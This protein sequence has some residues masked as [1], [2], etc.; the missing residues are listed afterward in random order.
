MIDF[1]HAHTPIFAHTHTDR[2]SVREKKEKNELLI[3]PSN[4]GVR[5]REGY[6]PGEI[7][8]NSHLSQQIE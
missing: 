8:Y 7:T 5:P 2:D 6:D 4:Y 3:L 1:F